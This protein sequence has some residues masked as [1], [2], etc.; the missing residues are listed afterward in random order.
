MWSLFY[1]NFTDWMQSSL[2]ISF[3]ISILLLGKF[4]RAAITKRRLCVEYVQKDARYNKTILAAFE[5]VTEFECVRRCARHL[6]CNAYNLLRGHG[7]CE[8]LHGLEACNE[9]NYR[10]GFKYV[11]LG[12]CE[13]HMP[14]AVGARSGTTSASCL[15]WYRPETLP[16]QACSAGMVTSPDQM[17]C[18]ALI[19]NKGMYLPGWFSQG[20]YGGTYRVITEDGQPMWCYNHGHVLRVVPECPVTWQPY[21]MG[22]PLPSEAGTVSTWKDGTPLF[23]VTKFINTQWYIGYLLPSVSRSYMM[24][25]ISFSPTDVHILVYVWENCNI[26]IG[27]PGCAD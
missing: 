3:C 25:E 6:K 7:L 2:G 19:F 12:A 13:G 10:H 20:I 27:I 5:N 4:G 8:I 16:V 18:V 15:K 9:T 22:D 21:T 1:D 11:H 17:A 26:F 14:W 23:F 24:A